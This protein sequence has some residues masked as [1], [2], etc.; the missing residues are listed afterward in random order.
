MGKRSTTRQRER[1][2]KA[3]VLVTAAAVVA[4]GTGVA[5][6][7]H[8]GGGSGVPA[9]V[10]DAGPIHTSVASLALS[11]GTGTDRSLAARSTKPFSSLGVTWTN[12]HAALT[13]TVEVRTHSSATGQWSGWVALAADEDSPDAAEADRPGVRGGTAPHWVGPS[14]GVQVQVRAAKGVTALPAGL[15][16]VLVDPGSTR[17]P[18]TGTAPVGYA[19]D[20][21]DSAGATPTDTVGA[22]PTASTTAPVTDASTDPAPTTP[23]PTGDV[24]S[25]PATTTADP[26]TDPSSAAPSTGVTAPS[27]TAT[28]SLTPTPT[29][30]PSATPWPVQLPSIA[31]AYP[32]GC[33]K[34]PPA[35]GQLP[36]TTLP[37]VTRSAIATPTVVSRSGW[38]ADE[39]AR[40]TGYPDYGTAV[41]VVFVHHTDDTNTYACT[42]SPAIVRSIYAYHLSQTWRD[43]GYNYLVDKC[44]TIFEGRFGGGALPV[45]GA[46]TYGFN[47][48]SM[49]IA[50][51]GTYTDL[52]VTVGGITKYGDS[53][54]SAV[55]GATPTKAMLGAIA[56]LAAW[57]L[58][59][60]GTSPVTGTGTLVQAG[61]VAGGAK[62]APGSAHTFTAVS[63]HRDGFATD[64]PG[65]QL[66]TALGA[67]RSYAAGPVTGL[68][69]TGISGGAVAS[70][71][72]WFT[73]GQATV[74]WTTATP[75]RVISGFDVLV[76]GQV[77]AHTGGSAVSAAIAVTPGSHS[78]KVVATHI[79]GSTASSVA[80]TLVG[81]TTAPSFGG[82]PVV[83][84]RTGAV[85]TAAVPVTVSWKASDAWALAS[86]SATAPS[87]AGFGPTTTT[88]ATTARPAT[89]D[90]FAL[91]AVDV[92][93]NVA[94]T[95]VTRTPVLVQET[96]A[97]RLGIW[98]R[99]ANSND[100][101]G[102]AYSS[103]ARGSSLSW[104]FT[105]RSISWIVTRSTT[106]GQAFLYLDGVYQGA[107]DTRATGTAYRQA[108][109]GKSWPT[110]GRHILKIVV[111]GTSGRPTVITDGF[112]LIG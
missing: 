68:A 27:A 53:K 45:I 89:A 38:G 6:V 82:V 64:C 20:A 76:D 5:A 94:T 91:R 16:V 26:T 12:A 10:T 70:A 67:I 35:A 81:D 56:D 51:I 55:K 33:K 62:Y 43:I 23:A 95:S 106:T 100:L 66:Y 80:V 110:S 72:R 17:S 13:G 74:S 25:A 29:P 49:G 57:K 63:G 77:K 92:A 105:G 1:G 24:S 52:P 36:P 93:G 3:R 90:L 71:G 37:P 22:D 103:S 44:G 32:A 98:T 87:A 88:W 54:S 97:S 28:P 46:Q 39:C 58:G 9:A 50:A 47:T 8:N 83:A 14:D 69:V 34:T 2:L 7:L 84:L 109:W 30:T 42:D 21:T 19:M 86:V 99:P 104:T 112:G 75:G 61:T 18:G 40:D 41:K 60:S 107:V 15:T 102:Y 79:T 31:A 96:S 59:M 73:K 111:T 78:V 108:V 65:N 85:T 101:G 48:N 11:A 4:A